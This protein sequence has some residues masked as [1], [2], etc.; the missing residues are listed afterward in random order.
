MPAHSG[1]LLVDA[2]DNLW[3]R[4]YSLPGELAFRWSVFDADGVFLGT[5]DVPEGLQLLDVGADRVLG[6]WRDDLGV[7]HVRMYELIKG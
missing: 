3:V 2:E 4:E 7:E 1:N 6:S 5:L